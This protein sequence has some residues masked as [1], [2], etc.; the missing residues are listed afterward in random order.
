MDGSSLTSRSEQPNSLNN[1]AQPENACVSYNRS[2]EDV[3]KKPLSETITQQ[4]L[5]SPLTMQ[6]EPLTPSF[7]VIT[8]EANSR[9][10]SADLRRSPLCHRLWK[11][12]GDFCAATFLCLQVNKDCIF[13]LGFFAAFVVSVSFLTAFFYHTLSMSPSLWQTTDDLRL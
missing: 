4:P 11:A 10:S 12:I 5:S 8:I 3:S 1:Y 2:Q 13:C 7:N 9:P 6:Q